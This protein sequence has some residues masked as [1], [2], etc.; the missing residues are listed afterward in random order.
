MDGHTKSM[1][2]QSRSLLQQTLEIYRHLDL[3]HD[4]VAET[5]VQIGGEGSSDVFQAKLS[6]NWRPRLDPNVMRLLELDNSKLT[7]TSESGNS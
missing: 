7:S 6:K 3:S 4:I 1:N 2:D 5:V